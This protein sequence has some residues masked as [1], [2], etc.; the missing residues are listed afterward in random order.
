MKELTLKSEDGEEIKVVIKKPTAKEMTEAKIFASSVLMKALNS[1]NPAP[2]R[3]QL[4]EILV[5]RGKMTEADIKYAETVQKKLDTSIAKMKKE[6]SLKKKRELAI[7][8]FRARLELISLLAAQ[9]DLDQFTAEALADNANFDYLVSVSV[10]TEEGERKFESIE[11]YYAQAN[12]SWVVECANALA[13]MT[14]QLP[15]DWRSN[16]PEC[17][18]LRNQNLMDDDYRLVNKEGE[19]VDEEYRRIDEEGYLINDNNE[20]IDTKGNLLTEE[21]E[22]DFGE[23]VDDL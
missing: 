8:S 23:V 6:K 3:K 5:E 9:R 22:E 19:L 4:Q 20:R 2:L 17:K 10:Y 7:K 15:E 11:D 18:F 14:G 12:Q 13:V 21:T 16:L 1:D